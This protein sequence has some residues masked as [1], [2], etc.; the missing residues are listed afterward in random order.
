LTVPR[1]TFYELL[2]ECLGADIAELGP[3]TRLREDLNADS[4][5]LLELLTMIEDRLGI[6]LPEEQLE[7]V[8]TVGEALNALDAITHEGS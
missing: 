4:L 7:D 1:E 2:E 3:K 5:Q 8:V 6:V